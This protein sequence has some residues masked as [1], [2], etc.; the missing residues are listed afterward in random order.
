MRAAAPNVGKSREGSSRL[1]RVMVF[2]SL[3][4]GAVARRGCAPGLSLDVP[5]ASIARH[6]TV[7]D[8]LSCTKRDPRSTVDQKA[9]VM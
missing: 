8:A 3:V 4:S 5:R 9:Y 1:E 7:H 2:E 6:D